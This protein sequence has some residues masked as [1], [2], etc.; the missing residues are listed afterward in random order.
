MTEENKYY[1]IGL[2]LVVVI[3]LP[4]YFLSWINKNEEVTE[5][6]TESIDLSKLVVH[7]VVLTKDGYSPNEI[8]IKKGEAVTFSTSENAF[9]WPASNIHPSHSIYPEFDP[10]TP[11]D[12]T[13]T[14]TFVFNNIGS[15]KYHDHLNPIFRGVVNVL[16]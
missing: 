7:D 1:Y 14:W 11:I 3:G 15:W 13:E 12:S 4:I 2:V 6:F 5:G 8:T 10:K 9:F 16:E